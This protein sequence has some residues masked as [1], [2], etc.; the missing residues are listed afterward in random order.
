MAY[1][2]GGCVGKTLVFALV[3]LVALGALSVKTQDSVVS[4]V[5]PVSSVASVPADVAVGQLETALDAIISVSARFI[6]AGGAVGLGVAA[7]I[8]PLRFAFSSLLVSDILAFVQS[9]TGHWEP[10]TGTVPEQPAVIAG[11][12]KLKRLAELEELTDFCRAALLCDSW[13]YNQLRTAGWG[14]GADRWKTLVTRVA[15]D[16]FAI[17]VSSNG[18]QGWAWVPKGQRGILDALAHY[19]G[20]LMTVGMP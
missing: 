10:G 6:L 14:G 12:D 16:G 9:I 11:N 4:T 17:K 5:A 19:A 7:V 20:E 2:P 13:T 3:V 1:S 18:G 15:S 8:I